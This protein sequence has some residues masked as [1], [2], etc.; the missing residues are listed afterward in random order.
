VAVVFVE[1][2]TCGVGEDFHDAFGAGGDV[3]A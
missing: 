2:V 3:A 1:V